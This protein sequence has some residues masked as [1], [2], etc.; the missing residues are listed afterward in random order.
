M[1]AQIISLRKYNLLIHSSMLIPKSHDRG[2]W[3]VYSPWDH[4]ELIQLS[5][6]KVTIPNII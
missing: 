1:R 5:T 4:K 2:T 3:Q 6:Y